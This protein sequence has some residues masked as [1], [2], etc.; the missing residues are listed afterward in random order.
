MDQDSREEGGPPRI[1]RKF[2]FR[3]IGP[4]V[5]VSLLLL[6]LG[7]ASAWYVQRLQRDIT[8]LLSR[9]VSSNRAAE[10]LVIAFRQI[11]AHGDGFMLTGSP[12][13]LDA[14]TAQFAETE[15]WL[16]EAER[17]AA[18]DPER[19][20]LASLRATHDLFWARMADLRRPVDPESRKRGMKS[21]IS[22]V[23]TG[24][25]LA[26]AQAYLDSK[27]QEVAMDSEQNQAMPDRVALVLLLLGTSG[28]AA[29]LIAGF[30]IARGVSRSIDQLSVPIRLAAG[31]LS[32]VV[33]PIR[34]SPDWDV[35]SLDRLLRRMADEVG[36][37]VERL[38]RTQREA[39]RA[40][41]LATLGQ[42]A[43]GLAHE[44]R[45]PLTAMKILVQSAVE[46]GDAA[47]LGGRSLAVLEEEIGRL[48]GSI[49]AFL[50][51]A[52]PPAPEKRR[53][54]L[55]EVLGGVLALV[56]ARAALVSVAI[57]R[58]PAE[59]TIS[60]EAD[61]GQ[62]RQV[63]LNLL[64]N[65]LDATPEGGTI[66][67]RTAAVEADE[68]A[69]GSADRDGTDAGTTGR[70]L[71]LRVADS[72]RGLPGDL[73]S[74]IFEPFVS[75]K[76]TGLGLGLSICKRIVE[77]HGGRIDAGHRPGGGAEFTVRLPLGDPTGP[78][79]GPA[80]VDDARDGGASEH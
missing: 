79:G 58:E 46:R 3:M 25:I 6:T 21:L 40:E 14:I 45:N 22:D 7:A 63:L 41:Q 19:A 55:D 80:R 20:R 48:E 56:S 64:L 5:A 2:L 78:S 53:F 23:L 34:L 13:Y 31:K 18:N 70:H 49:Q 35:E 39:L 62:V 51:F 65:A 42:L 4:V 30:G 38:E 68:F 33:G 60:V 57:V 52:R 11:E 61:T 36:T 16:G 43:A 50:D 67:V 54:D 74:R 37:V 1:A 9:D 24:G 17:L 29:G 26:P 32:G 72:G 59:G 47:G 76:E 44:L 10:E 8:N 75:T 27:E 28:A 77:A 73:G 71:A 69:H 66:W 12:I 15:R